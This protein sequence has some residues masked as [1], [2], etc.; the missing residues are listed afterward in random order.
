MTK[1][2]FQCDECENMFDGDDLIAVQYAVGST[3][4]VCA[5]CADEKFEKEPTVSEDGFASARWIKD[6]IPQLGNIKPQTA[7][8]YAEKWGFTEYI[9]QRFAWWDSVSSGSKSHGSPPESHKLHKI[10]PNGAAL[11]YGSGLFYDTDA[12]TL[13]VNDR[14]GSTNST[15]FYFGR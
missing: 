3:G 11:P 4:H 1:Q 2:K 8:Q 10:L 9:G 13:L 15:S 5:K 6:A 12:D 14:L 7:I